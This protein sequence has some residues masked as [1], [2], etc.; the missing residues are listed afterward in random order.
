MAGDTNNNRM[1]S[2][3]GN[4]VRHRE[5]VIRGLKKDDSSHL[6]G[7]RLYYNHTRL[8]QGLPDGQTPDEA[9]D[10]KIEGDNK[11]KTVIQAAAKQKSDD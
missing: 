9:A 2:F 4:T 7:L 1:E 5:K 8:H 6:I 11:W 10:I 3:S